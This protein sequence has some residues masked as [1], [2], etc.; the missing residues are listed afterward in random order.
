MVWTE[1]E[2]RMYEGHTNALT[3]SWMQPVR[4]MPTIVEVIV[5]VNNRNSA[6]FHAHNRQPDAAGE[7]NAHYCGSDCVGEQQE[8]RHVPHEL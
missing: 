1:K 5:W 2:R 6:M 3:V 4:L 8:Q 7:T